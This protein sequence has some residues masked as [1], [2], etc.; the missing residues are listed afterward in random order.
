MDLE[1]IERLQIMR[2][3]FLVHQASDKAIYITGFLIFMSLLV[4]ILAKKYRVPIVVGYV[5]LGIGL[6]INVIEW[7]PFL[8][9]E[10]KEWY[11]F[12]IE[13][14]DYIANFALA[15]I[16]FTIGSELSLKILKSLGKKI[17][18]I[19]ILEAFGA[20]VIVSLAILAI[21]KPLYLALVLGAIASATA[22]AATVMVLK[23][24]NA[25]GLLTSMILA[26][27][28][29]DDAIALI[30]FSLVEPIALS[31]YLG[32]GGLSLSHA[33]L[34]PVIEIVGSVLIGILI[35]YL[36]QKFMSSIEDKTKKILNLVTTIVG[37]S[38]IAILF[39]LSPLITNMA[40][41]FAYRNFARKNLGIAE[42]METL[43]V[44]L[45]A[46][47]F[48]LAGTEIRLDSIASISF[49][50]L[51]FVYTLARVI[52]KVGGAS[53]G[54]YLSNAPEKIKK[55][56]GL[57]LLPQSGVAIALAYTVQKHFVSP[58]GGFNVGL[59]VFNTLL[60]TAALTE[61]FGPLATKYAITKAGEIGEGHKIRDN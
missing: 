59:L 10:Q 9:A 6:S 22:P 54:A 13:G 46:F 28:G 20:F 16:A 27:V 53:L 36:S 32:Q 8:S 35:G 60:F 37:G 57:G 58:T 55:Y 40:I 31:L 61:V 43:T 2:E 19:A 17:V 15:F 47:F 50:T 42:Y 26:I 41:G 52:G 5:F 48:I 30:I 29:I 44:P 1:L 23:E 39:H 14:F 56:V 11:A 7:L 38:A 25:E 33:V 24:Y 4:V 18:Y 12:T 34:A 3:W 49:L 51:A 45:Y 21:G